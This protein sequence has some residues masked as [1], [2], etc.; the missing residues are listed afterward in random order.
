MA[1]VTA[2]LSI[3]LFVLSSFPSPAQAIPPVRWSQDSVKAAIL[4]GGHTEIQVSLN[5]FET[6]GN[7]YLTAVPEIAPYVDIS[8]STL[9]N[10]KQ[11]DIIPI[12]ISIQADAAAELGLMKGV[13]QVREQV[14]RRG[15][16]RVFARPLPVQVLIED[17]VAGADVDGN[18]VWDYIDQYIDTKYPGAADDQLRSASRQYARAVQ[19]GILNPD[20]KQM[21]L[22][23]AT[24]SD[25]AT[26]CVF[27][28]RPDD[29]NSILAD[30]ESA[31]LNT[32]SRSKAFLMFSEQSAGQVFASTPSSE[33][34]ASCISE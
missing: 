21:S 10:V 16:G 6:I 9:A 31:I 23:Y 8:P 18:G 1:L 3:L 22:Q 7:V 33:R 13:I 2:A 11:G 32:E 26:E 4:R 12:R 29:A 24:D 5:S 19:G 20:S 14:T 34:S 17:G 15:K 30:L 27:H 25:R 28:L